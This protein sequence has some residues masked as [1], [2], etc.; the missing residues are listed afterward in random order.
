MKLEEG[1]YIRTD[2]GKIG[3]IIYFEGTMAKTDNKKII[4]F[5]DFNEEIKKASHNIIDLIE[6]GDYVNG[7]YVESFYYDT[8]EYKKIGV[9]TTDNYWMGSYTPTENIKSIVTKE[10]FE[11]MQYEVK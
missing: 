4:T 5:K 8:I 2:Y 6:E 10:Q 1:M 7:E 3:K 9:E 11:S